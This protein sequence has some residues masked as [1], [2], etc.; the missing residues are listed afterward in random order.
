[1][2]FFM[3]PIGMLYIVRVQ[4]AIAYFL[5][6]IV[7]GAADFWLALSKAEWG[8]YFSFG[9]VLMIICPVHIYLIVKQNREIP[10]RPWYSR[11]Y[12][13]VSF[14]LLL[15]FLIFSFRAFLFEPFRM[16]ASSMSPLVNSG[17][18]LVA[19]KWGYGNYATYGITL[20]KSD[21]SKDVKRGEVI[22]F[23]YP[24]DPSTNYVKRVIGLP[25]DIIEFDKDYLIV[26]GEKALRVFET[27]DTDFEV[28]S[29][30]ISDISYRIKVMPNRPSVKGNVTVPERHLFVMG[31]NRDNSNDSRFW[32]FVPFE[33]I[34]GKVVY[35]FRTGNA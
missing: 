35:I 19:N 24:K 7:T 29:E 18:I 3:Q 34:V 25:G 10:I 20:V 9:F 16:P 5:A 1:M 22:V 32:G 21:L 28:F 8:Q 27:N 31:D 13:L 11:W 23:E 4:L 15:M 17:D 6:G 30:S 14:P 26:N 2:G 33:N 12:G